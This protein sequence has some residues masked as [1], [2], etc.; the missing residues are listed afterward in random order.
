MTAKNEESIPA[1]RS[2]PTQQTQHQHHH[3]VIIGLLFRAEHFV[4]I[5]VVT[6]LRVGEMVRKSA[7][8]VQMHAAFG[9]GAQLRTRPGSQK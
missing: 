4:T 1:K 6:H 8:R 3:N 9:V 5:A 7:V 2:T